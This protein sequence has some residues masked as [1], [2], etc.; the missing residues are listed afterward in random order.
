MS[1][2]ILGFCEHN[3]LV[4]A[5]IESISVEET[6]EDMA[7]SYRLERADEAKFNGTCKVCE[8]RYEN[9]KK[10]LAASAVEETKS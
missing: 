3:I 1:K 4:A 8:E 9:N 2:M 5:A 10:L 6:L 7:V